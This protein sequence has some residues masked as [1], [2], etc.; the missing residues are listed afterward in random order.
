MP[1][2]Q[3]CQAIPFRKSLQQMN[4][5][6]SVRDAFFWYHEPWLDSTD[7]S[8]QGAYVVW[9]EDVRSLRQSAASCSFCHLIQNDLDKSYH[10]TTKVKKGEK[11]KVWLNLPKQGSGTSPF[12]R[13][14][15]QITM[16]IGDTR[17]EVHISGNWWFGTTPGA[18]R[19]TSDLTSL[20]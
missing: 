20:T 3:Q 6:N 19:I 16:W 9:H 15:P 12:R 1:L 2:C 11:R 13:G 4:G 5:D 7:D 18:T 8:L 10:Y 14:N 17:P